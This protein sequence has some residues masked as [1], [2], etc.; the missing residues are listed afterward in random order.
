MIKIGVTGG[1]GS[2]KS[3]LCDIFAADKGIAVYNSDK[4][5]QRL[6]GGELREA[7]VGEFGS[8]VFVDGMLNRSYLAEVVFGDA[9]ALKRLNAIVHPAV[10]ADFQ[11]W[12]ESEQGEYVIVES[13]ILFDAGFDK[14]VD[15]TLV[16]LAPKELRLER[17][18]KR[19][20]VE[21]QAIEQR[22]DAQMSDEELHSR[23]NYSIVNIFEEDLAPSVVKLDMLFRKLANK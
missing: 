15:Y 13:A 16:V 21:K 12:S 3:T 23:A 7:L 18:C 11:R 22:M 14:Y 1:I 6:M 2:G 10:R 20:G 8:S 17:A 19:D 9:D 4:S 5:A